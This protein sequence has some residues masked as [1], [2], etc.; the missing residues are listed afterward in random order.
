[1]PGCLDETPK[2]VIMHYGIIK[3]KYDFIIYKL[4]LLLFLAKLGVLGQ[5]S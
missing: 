3:Q 2:F 4:I 1:M 5:Y